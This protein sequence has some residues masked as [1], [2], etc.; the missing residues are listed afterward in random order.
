MPLAV[1]GTGDSEHNVTVHFVNAPPGMRSGLSSAS[2][3]AGFSLR[4]E[5][6]LATP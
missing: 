2:G 3:T 6:A 1:A 4:T 5:H